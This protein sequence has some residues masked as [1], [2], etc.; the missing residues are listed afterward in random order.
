MNTQHYEPVVSSQWKL[1]AETLRDDGWV[2]TAA[3]LSGATNGAAVLTRCGRRDGDYG[4][5]ARGG[6]RPRVLLSSAIRSTAL[7]YS[8]AKS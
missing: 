2:R 6:L 8:W 5:F 4:L 1:I 3:P 7:R